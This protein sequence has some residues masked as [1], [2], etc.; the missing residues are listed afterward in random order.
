MTRALFVCAL[1]AVPTLASAQQPETIEYYGS[2]VIGSIRIVYDMN[3]NVIG[4]QDYAPF[5]T[6]V[7][8]GTS[9][10]KEGFGGNEKDDE[11][12]QMDFHARSLIARAGRFTSVDSIF[13]AKNEPS[14]WN[15]YAYAANNPLRFADSTGLETQTVNCGLGAYWCPGSMPIPGNPN[16]PTDS[17]FDP[18]QY[19]YQGGEEMDRAE[20]AYATNVAIQFAQQVASYFANKQAEAQANFR[21]TSGPL[22]GDVQVKINGVWQGCTVDNGCIKLG[23]ALP[24]T[25][26]GIGKAGEEIV[27]SLAEIG[28]KAA[29]EIGGRLRIADG[30]L[31]E[32]ITEVKNVRYQALT[33]QIQDY[34]AYAQAQGM[35]FDLWV[36]SGGGTTLSGPL[37]TAMQVG[38][39]NGYAMLRT[40]GWP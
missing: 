14:R 26:F 37:Q 18:S 17:H 31:D 23:I 30:M 4:R 28:D 9:M 24:D 1:L 29:F 8:S 35:R 32:I 6:P 21:I 22:G 7:L 20:E 16:T 2:D 3:G 36:R 15:R 39:K 12:Q 38:I 11:T 33:G 19:G 40:F 10:P 27:R 25:P 34:L 13:D 5:G